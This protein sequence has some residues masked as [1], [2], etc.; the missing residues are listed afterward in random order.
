MARICVANTSAPQC[1]SKDV[2]H[3]TGRTAVARTQPTYLGFN[4][5]AA[6]FGDGEDVDFVRCRARR[7]RYRRLVLVLLG[8]V[9][10]CLAVE[11]GGA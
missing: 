2:A 11:G 9:K 8:L 6:P 5:E 3:A 10:I 1:L 7:V 4:L